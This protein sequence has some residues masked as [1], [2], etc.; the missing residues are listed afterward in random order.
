MS[1]LEVRLAWEATREVGTVL[2]A[3]REAIGL[4][5][6]LT[7]PDAMT[8]VAD[9]FETRLAESPARPPKTERHD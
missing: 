5:H 4:P 2:S 7:P 9:S 6:E 1:D 3:E 8:M